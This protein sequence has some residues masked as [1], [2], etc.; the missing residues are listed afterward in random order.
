MLG[1]GYVTQIYSIGY[2]DVSGPNHVLKTRDYQLFHFETGPYADFF[3]PEVQEPFS[4]K[5]VPESLIGLFDQVQQ[6][7]NRGYFALGTLEPTKDAGLA[8]KLATVEKMIN[9][10]DPTDIRDNGL[11]VFAERKKGRNETGPQTHT[12]FATLRFARSTQTHRLLPVEENLKIELKRSKPV[13]LNATEKELILSKFP[14]L[15]FVKNLKIYKGGIIE[16]KGLLNL[17]NNPRFDLVKHLYAE[18]VR[19]NILYFGDLSFADPENPT[20]TIPDLV[21]GN[22]VSIKLAKQLSFPK[23]KSVRTSSGRKLYVTEGPIE[24]LEAAFL[25]RS[26]SEFTKPNRGGTVTPESLGTVS[27]P[28]VPRIPIIRIEP[29]PAELERL[30]AIR[31]KCLALISSL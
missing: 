10:T 12:I 17:E 9:P 29:T 2:H 31:K 7:I 18:A 3:F 25:T 26:R 24:D 28:E 8:Q 1:S 11:I 23:G 21:V 13:L 19:S 22:F 16:I 6:I 14:K 20:L 27:L 15:R 5:A 4:F 30:D